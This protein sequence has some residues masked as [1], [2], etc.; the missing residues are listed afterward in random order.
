MV[1]LYHVY[2]RYGSAQTLSD[3]TFKVDKGEFIYITGPSG[4]GKSTLLNILFCSISFNEGQIVV[5]GKNILKM[6]DSSIPYYRRDIGMVFQDF[7]LLTHK[8]IFQNIGFAQHAVGTWGAKAKQRVWWKLKDVGLTTK[9]DHYPL[10][11]SG[12]EQQRVAVARA[13]IN[14]PKIVMADEPTGNLDEQMSNQI[15]RLLQKANEEGATVLFAT[16]N[17]RL[18]ENFPARVIRLDKGRMVE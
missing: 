6:R 2:K 16:H 9:K 5:N 4:A 14:N 18:I 15:I 12:G 17:E 1:N 10:E 11:L 8:T 3:I 7:Q 13:L